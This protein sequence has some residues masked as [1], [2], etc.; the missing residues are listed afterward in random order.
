MIKQIWT[1][2]DPRR[3][4]IGLSFAVAGLMLFYTLI[5]L[6]YIPMPHPWSGIDY[7]AVPVISLLLCILWK[8]LISK[9]SVLTGCKKAS[10]PIAL[11]RQKTLSKDCRIAAMALMTLILAFVQLDILNKAKALPGFGLAVPLFC[12]V[13][14]LFS[15]IR[16]RSMIRR[17]SK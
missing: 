3:L 16:F 17:I 14:W 2:R 1:I 15:S 8:V 13:A 10:D 6:P 5:N 7:A 12:L 4:F 9:N 11:D